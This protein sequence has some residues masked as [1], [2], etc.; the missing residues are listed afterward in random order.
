MPLKYGGNLLML[1]HSQQN[2]SL[3]FMNLLEDVVGCH[4]LEMCE[5]STLE[6]RS[7]YA[8]LQIWCKI[9]RACKPNGYHAA[10]IQA[11]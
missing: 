7:H 6:G 3:A 8:R 2:S 11:C 4:H 10:H 1:A 5:L 9:N